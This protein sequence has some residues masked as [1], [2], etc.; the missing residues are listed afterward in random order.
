MPIAAMIANNPLIS[1]TA[2]IKSSIIVFPKSYIVIVHE[3]HLL[4]TYCN[5]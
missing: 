2:S 3:A 4:E 1:V 5:Q